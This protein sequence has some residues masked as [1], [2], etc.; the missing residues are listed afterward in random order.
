MD[1]VKYT[2]AVVLYAAHFENN[3]SC[4]KR[5]SEMMR[6]CCTMV[7]MFLFIW[8]ADNLD[9]LIESYIYNNYDNTATVEITPE[10]V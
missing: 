5:V 8:M 3:S 10:F 2:L 4:S 6:T 1:Q 9:Y 7:P